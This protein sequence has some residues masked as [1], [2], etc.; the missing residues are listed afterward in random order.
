[1]TFAHVPEILSGN[2]ILVQADQEPS[3]SRRVVIEEEEG[4][5]GGLD[6]H[7]VVCSLAEQSTLL[8]DLDFSGYSPF[9]DLE[10]MPLQLM[11]RIAS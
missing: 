7:S 4:G 10:E 8:A 2:P 6:H 9:S 3:T 11:N 1:M 5:G